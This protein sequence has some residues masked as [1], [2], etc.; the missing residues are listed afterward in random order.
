MP[1]HLS[2]QLSTRRDRVIPRALQLTIVHQAQGRG[3]LAAIS[4][5]WSL[6]HAGCLQAPTA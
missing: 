1:P 6:N 4:F 3:G 2:M 5:P